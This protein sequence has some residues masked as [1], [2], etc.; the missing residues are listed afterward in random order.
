[1]PAS[2]RKSAS[3]KATT[4]ATEAT[5]VEPTTE[6]NGRRPR[7]D[8]SMLAASATAVDEMPKSSRVRESSVNEMAE[9]VRTS[10]VNAQ[11]YE[12]PAVSS[13]DEVKT[14]TSM[15]RRAAAM[16]GLGVSIR[17][18]QTSDNEYVVTFRAKD[19]KKS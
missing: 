3:A 2:A 8:L 6:T 5:E 14:I 18:T 7:L 13:D 12:L 1:M 19:K 17:P 16:A 4:P 9:L 10:Y 11:A 15:L